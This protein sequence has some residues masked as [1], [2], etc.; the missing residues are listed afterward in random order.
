[1]GQVCCGDQNLG[2]TGSHL[3]IKLGSP[4]KSSKLGKHVKNI[5]T[6]ICT[7]FVVLAFAANAVAKPSKS[8]I[9]TGAQRVISGQMGAEYQINSFSYKTF[10]GES[11]TGRVSV[12]G[13]VKLVEPIFLRQ[14][15]LSLKADLAEQGFSAS[16]ISEVFERFS[17]T[18]YSVSRNSGAILTFELELSYTEKVSGYRF[19]KQRFSA[20]RLRGETQSEILDRNQKT[21][22]IHAIE[23]SRQYKDF[24]ETAKG[25]LNERRRQLARPE[26]Y[27]VSTKQFVEDFFSNEVLIV[28][29]TVVHPPDTDW[30]TNQL[31]PEELVSGTSTKA[32]CKNNEVVW[33]DQAE[34]EVAKTTLWG[35]V[36]CEVEGDTFHNI[37][38]QANGVQKIGYVFDIHYRQDSPGGYEHFTFYASPLLNKPNDDKCRNFGEGWCY[39]KPRM[40]FNAGIFR[41]SILTLRPGSLAR[42]KQTT[43]SLVRGNGEFSR[44]EEVTE[45]ITEEGTGQEAS[46]EAP[47]TECDVQAAT[48]GDPDKVAA[49]VPYKDLNTR[50]A[51]GA[52]RSAVEEYPNAPRFAAQLGR[53][54]LKLQDNQNAERW[55]RLGAERGNLIAQHNLGWLQEEVIKNYPEAVKWYTLAAEQG[56]HPSQ[57]NFASLLIKGKGVSRDT[58]EGLKWIIISEKDSGSSSSDFLLSVRRSLSQ[59]DVSLAKRAAEEWTA[60]TWDELQ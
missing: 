12:E 31:L 53:V 37:S 42:N 44:L 41:D 33:L 7:F 21:G 26:E 52:C 35:Y 54:Y 29:V 36:L 6:W 14:S 10:P 17:Y 51:L 23:N 45:E 58:V 47:M 8:Q 4:K 18:E 19:R 1:M 55:L 56:F 20:T 5:L 2:D 39:S 60:K 16:E 46:P 24:L 3:M 49:G 48:D 22:A 30:M 50:A 40:E 15:S 25:F 59:S 32:T 28:T 43:H 57:R 13:A 27:V 38:L 11:G 9:R 34:S